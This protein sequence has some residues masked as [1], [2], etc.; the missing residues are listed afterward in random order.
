MMIHTGWFRRGYVIDCFSWQ[1]SDWNTSAYAHNK[2]HKPGV[3][4][5]MLRLLVNKRLNEKRSLLN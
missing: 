1:K 5:N 2:V 4:I 3:S